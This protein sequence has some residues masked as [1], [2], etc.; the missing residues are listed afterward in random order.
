VVAEPELLGLVDHE[1]PADAWPSDE[2]DIW[3]ADHLGRPAQML[4]AVL[5]PR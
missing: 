2:R 4:G 5:R 1:T 3:T